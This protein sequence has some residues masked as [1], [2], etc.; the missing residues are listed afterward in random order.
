MTSSTGT[1]VPDGPADGT[2]GLRGSPVAGPR[3]RAWAVEVGVLVLLFTAYNVIRAGWG[4][5]P[6]RA[7]EN[8]RRIATGEGWIFRAVE[9]TL[10]DWLLHAPVLAVAA[11]YFYALMH[12]V[13]TPVVLLVSRRHGGWHYWR[14]YWGIVLASAIG[15]VG[16]AL[17][18]TAPPRLMPDLGV[19]DIMRHFADYGWWGDAASAPRGALLGLASCLGLGVPFAL[20][21]WGFGW[22]QRSTTFLR[23]HLRTIN[24][25]GGIVLMLIG[26]AMVTG[27]WSLL[28][29][30]VQ[31]WVKGFVTPI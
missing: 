16:Y 14:G 22:A 24:V 19:V 3:Y 10:N 6:A 8:A 18:P 12:Y 5:D 20:I 11:C 30:T 9:A 1:T 7:F 26:L 27:A 31:A 15:L 23:T 13:M 25:A 29:T 17:L 28:M 4:D 2:S 21:A